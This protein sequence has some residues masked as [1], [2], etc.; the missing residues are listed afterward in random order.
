LNIDDIS[1]ATNEDMYAF[2]NVVASGGNIM[3]TIKRLDKS[4]E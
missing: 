4:N 2:S 1:T 3:Q